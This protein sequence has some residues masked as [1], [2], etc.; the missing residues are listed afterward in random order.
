M[1]YLNLFSPETWSQV[2][3]VFSVAFYLLQCYAGYKC[4]KWLVAVV[5]FVV[6]F[7]IGFFV[8]AGVFTQDAYIP[9][10][11][12]IA[13]G[14]GLAFVAFKLYLVGIFIYCGSIAY[15]AVMSLPIPNEGSYAVLSAVLGIAA[16]IIVGI[17]AVKFSKLCLI[18]SIIFENSSLNN[19]CFIIIISANKSSFP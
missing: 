17:L 13:A 9:A 3:L 4:I 12:G 16:F 5:G 7:L 2:F 1:H 18:S 6:G 10:V 19:I 11:I 14:I 8:S 15:Q